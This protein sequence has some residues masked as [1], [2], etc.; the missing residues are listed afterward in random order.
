MSHSSTASSSPPRLRLSR[1][2]HICG[3]TM[4]PAKLAD[5]LT[6]RGEAEAAGALRRLSLPPSCRVA[7][8]A[9]GRS[10]KLEVR[11]VLR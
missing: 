3:G 1:S 10:L 5:W 6:R 2:S 7:W 9:A 4:P 11:H 8:T